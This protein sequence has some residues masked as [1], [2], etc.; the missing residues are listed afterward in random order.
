MVSF[1]RGRRGQI[2]HG[3]EGTSGQPNAIRRWEFRRSLRHYRAGAPS[4]PF[5]RGSAGGERREAPGESTARGLAAPVPSRPTRRGRISAGHPGFP[6]T[7]FP[8]RRKGLE[9]ADPDPPPTARLQP[10]AQWRLEW[11]ESRYRRRV[12][13]MVLTRFRQG[14]GGSDKSSGVPGGSAPARGQFSAN[15]S[16]GA[17]RHSEGPRR[18]PWAAASD[19]RAGQGCGAETLQGRGPEGGPHRPGEDGLTDRPVSRPRSG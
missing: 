7:G 1:G 12:V 19:R 18:E 17:G 2:R 5:D 13:E 15:R 10:G 16:G 3:R 9:T 14:H 4:K 6:D 8:D 11:P